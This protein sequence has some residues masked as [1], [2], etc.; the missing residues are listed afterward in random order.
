MQVFWYFS[1][2]YKKAA[3]IGNH[4]IRFYVRKL[5]NSKKLITEL[6]ITFW[7]VTSIYY[8]FYTLSPLQRSFCRFNVHQVLDS[9]K[10]LRKEKRV[11][12]KKYLGLLQVIEFII[13]HMR[14]PEDFLDEV[15]D[16]FSEDPDPLVLSKFI[17]FRKTSREVGRSS[18]YTE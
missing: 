1:W 3:I 9:E 4:S 2:S 6:N 12:I 18:A 7:L 5:F 15:L 17:K 13:G 8:L 14:I 10:N 16:I 11:S